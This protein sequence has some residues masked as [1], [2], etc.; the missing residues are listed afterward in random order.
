MLIDFQPHEIWSSPSLVLLDFNYNYINHLFHPDHT[1]YQLKF[2]NIH[3]TIKHKTE[4]P[5]KLPEIGDSGHA[6]HDDGR[7]ESEKPTSVLPRTN[8][9][10]TMNIHNADVTL[11]E[12]YSFYGDDNL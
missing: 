12:I 7:H 8:K 11:M 5:Y 9:H 4:N 10:M 3:M 1:F 6:K 2:G